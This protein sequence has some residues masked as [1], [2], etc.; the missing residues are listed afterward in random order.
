MAINDD[1]L[2]PLE[3]SSQNNCFGC[4]A[5]N[6]TGLQLRFSVAPD[7][8][9]VSLINLGARF[10]GPPGFIHGGILA[11]LMDE[12]MS[13]TLR[14][15]GVTAMTRNMEV[16]YLRPA[17]IETPLRIEAKH[18]RE[19]GR[20]HWCEAVLLDSKGRTL[21][22]GKGLFIALDPELVAAHLARSK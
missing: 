19:E 8:T 12:A 1:E 16:D 18:L 11:T 17:P 9:I 13:K 4:G 22:S 15:R 5:A 20:K 7:G 21:T 2:K 10:T 14:A 6:E 3:H